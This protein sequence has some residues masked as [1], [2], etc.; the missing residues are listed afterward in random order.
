MAAQ[1]VHRLGLWRIGPDPQGDPIMRGRSTA[2]TVRSQESAASD[3]RAYFDQPLDCEGVASGRAPD[4]RA[5]GPVPA[6]L[7]A[8]LLGGKSCRGICRVASGLM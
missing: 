3:L 2:R 4:G 1:G 5:R 7:I 6:E 8:Y